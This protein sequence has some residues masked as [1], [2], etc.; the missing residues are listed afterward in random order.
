MEKSCQS[1]GD[2]KQAYER[3][4]NGGKEKQHTLECLQ[5]KIQNYVGSIEPDQALVD[6][7]KEAKATIWRILRDSTQ[8]ADKQFD[9]LI[10]G[11][12]ANGLFCRDTSDLDLTLVVDPEKWDNPKEILESAYDALH[13]ENRRSK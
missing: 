5:K 3:F 4:M 13:Q 6:R 10:F 11:S 8:F 2:L 1:N 12:F 9:L 7:I